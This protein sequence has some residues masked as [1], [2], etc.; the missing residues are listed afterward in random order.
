M[1]ELHENAFEFYSEDEIATLSLH[2]KK[3]INRI[4]KLKESH[5]DEVDYIEN[6]DGTM[7]VHLPVCW[8]KINPSRKM[9]EEQL[10]DL[11]ARFSKNLTLQ[12]EI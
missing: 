4:K 1:A 3:Y 7:I 12:G 2:K 11:R 9:S 8:L 10:E 6:Q 5:P